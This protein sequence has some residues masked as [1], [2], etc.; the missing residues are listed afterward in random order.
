MMSVISPVNAPPI[1]LKTSSLSSVFA[2]FGISPLF[3][4]SLSLLKSLCHRGFHLPQY[5]VCFVV[6]GNIHKNDNSL[7]IAQTIVSC[8]HLLDHFLLR[9]VRPLKYF[10]PKI[11]KMLLNLLVTENYISYS[12]MG[13]ISVFW[14]KPLLFTATVFIIILQYFPVLFL[15]QLLLLPLK[16]HSFW[17]HYA[18]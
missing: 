3:S 2:S 18:W 7:R 8:F 4:F 16:L 14:K 1:M 15:L 10:F 17:R 12:A 11:I 9:A 13:L 6:Y 5:A